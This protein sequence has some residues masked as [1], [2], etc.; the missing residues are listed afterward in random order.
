MGGTTPE[1]GDWK[2]GEGYAHDILGDLNVGSVGW[3]DWNILL[4]MSGGPNHVGNNC[5]AP[6]FVDNAKNELY[7]HPQYYYIGH[8]SKYLVRGSRRIKASVTGSRSY[9]GPGRPYG[10]CTGEDGLQATSFLRPDDQIAV[11][12]M[13]C[14]DKPVDFVLKAGKRNALTTVPAHGIQTYLFPKDGPELSTRNIL[15]L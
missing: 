5:D 15:Y 2:M 13:N 8:F 11:V 3:T 6:M 9:T 7:L 14:D 4:D 10:T 1:A 12:V